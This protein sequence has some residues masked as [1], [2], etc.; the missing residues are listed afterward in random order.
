MEHFVEKCDVDLLECCHDRHSKITPS[1][2]RL[3][4]AFR[5]TIP[6][7]VLLKYHKNVTAKQ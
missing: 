7:S 4:A 1:P 6:R 2:D 3:L 5:V